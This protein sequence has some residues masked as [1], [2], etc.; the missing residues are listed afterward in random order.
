[1]D[2][3]IDAETAES[4]RHLAQ[5]WGISEQ[6]A[7]RR[8]IKGAEHVTNGRLEAFR[9]L[10]SLMQMTPEKAAAWTAAIKEARR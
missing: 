10:Q 6:E 9:E 7:L 1:M 2:V 8:A 4:L 3:Q 5:S